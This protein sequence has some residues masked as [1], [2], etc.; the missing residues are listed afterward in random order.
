LGFLLFFYSRHI[1]LRNPRHP[2][3][4]HVNG[5][6]RT[7][8]AG[9]L[10]A[11][12]LGRTAPRGRSEKYQYTYN[13]IAGSAPL[14]FIIS[15]VVSFNLLCM[16]SFKSSTFSYMLSFLS[17][18]LIGSENHALCT[19]VFTHIF[20]VEPA[21]SSKSAVGTGKYIF[22]LSLRVDKTER[23]L[24]GDSVTL[25][26]AVDPRQLEFVVLYVL[27][28]SVPCRSTN[29]LHSFLCLPLYSSCHVNLS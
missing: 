18:H 13:L 7:V 5:H 11:L 10:G 22:R 9:S 15:C 21:A 29:A 14:Q 26:L 3:H 6:G 23:P 16:R 4:Q 24:P 27:H 20:S 25:N 2:F 17:Y 12:P 1:Y 19:T 8:S 28:L